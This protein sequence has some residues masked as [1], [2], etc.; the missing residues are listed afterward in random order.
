MNIQKKQE[1]LERKMKNKKKAEAGK[2]ALDTFYLRRSLD[3]LI[4]EYGYREVLFE[5]IKKQNERWH[6]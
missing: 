5:I 2:K 4:K 6:E 1:H 3:N